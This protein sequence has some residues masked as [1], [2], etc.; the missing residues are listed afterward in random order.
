MVKHDRP[1]KTELLPEI[2]K[3]RFNL[4]MVKDDWHPWSRILPEILKFRF[5]LHMVK[6]D[7]P[8]QNRISP[9]I[10]KF[11][12]SLHMVKDRLTPFFIPAQISTRNF[13]SLD[14]VFTWWKMID[15]CLS[16]PP[17]PNFPRNFKV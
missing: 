12:F 11:T 17:A 10:L 7:L 15:P 3:F 13:K 2:L 4:H 6:D 8:P 16:L 14:L 1:P 9:E 5:S